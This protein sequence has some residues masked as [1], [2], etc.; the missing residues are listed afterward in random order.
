MA[1]S[2]SCASRGKH[3]K[4][5]GKR[6]FVP[7]RGIVERKNCTRRTSIEHFW[8]VLPYYEDWSVSLQTLNSL[9]ASRFIREDDTKP[10]RKTIDTTRRGTGRQRD[11]RNGGTIRWLGKKFDPPSIDREFFYDHATTYLRDVCL[12][13]TPC[14]HLGRVHDTPPY[15]LTFV[16]TELAKAR[17]TEENGEKSKRNR[18]RT[19]TRSHLCACSY[20]YTLETNWKRKGE[21]GE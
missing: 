10:W 9:C 7:P 19:D 5:F 18:E 17:S 16:R 11:S 12:A 1:F 14:I 20:V 13:T 8:R 2:R 6:S 3:Q 4:A 15:V 21:K